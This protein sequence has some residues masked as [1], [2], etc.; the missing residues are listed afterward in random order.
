MCRKE[1]LE[2]II[3]RLEEADEYTVQ[4]VYDYLQE[5]EY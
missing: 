3:E 2:Y 4:Q 5:V 1:M